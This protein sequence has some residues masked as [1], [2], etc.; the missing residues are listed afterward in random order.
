MGKSLYILEL[1]ESYGI[2]RINIIGYTY[3]ID[4]ATTIE[5]SY[6]DDE[7][8]YVVISEVKEILL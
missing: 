8:Y 4:V 1:Y 6:E 3:S 2:E 5:K 7:N